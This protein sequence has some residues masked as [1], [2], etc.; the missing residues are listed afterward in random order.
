[1]KKIEKLKEVLEDDICFPFSQDDDEDSDI[2]DIEKILGVLNKIVENQNLIIDRL[3]QEVSQ[4]EEKKMKTKFD[5]D[6]CRHC[7]SSSIQIVGEKMSWCNDCGYMTYLGGKEVENNTEEGKLVELI[8]RHYNG[9]KV[10]RKEQDK[11]DIEFEKLWHGYKI[12]N[13]ED[14]TDDHT[15]RRIVEAIA[16][17]YCTIENEGKV[18][19][20]DLCI[21]MADEVVNFV[22]QLLS[23]RSFSKEELEL[24]KDIIDGCD[25][26]DIPTYEGKIDSL[27]EKVDRLLSLEK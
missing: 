25:E 17:G 11:K 5:G 20:S 16:R 2:F 1:M 14:W 6:V 26:W 24:A 3:N 19:D 27:S 23:E 21:A 4:P 10:A 13:T 15:R 9:W 12:D 7:G 22:E 8:K 18:I